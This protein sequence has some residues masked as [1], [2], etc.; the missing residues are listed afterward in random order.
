MVHITRI[1]KGHLPSLQ[2]KQIKDKILGKNYELSLVFTNDALSKSLHKKWQGKSGP[3]NIL[4]FP[5]S[6]KNGEIFI[7]PRTAY[8][9]S[10]KF[11]YP[12]FLFLGFLFIHG[13]CHL[14]GL[15]HGQ[16]MEKLE[17]KYRKMFGIRK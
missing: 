13:C 2:Y 17:E 12:N 3:A 11:G 8:R 16:K 10:K 14:K 7:N 4:S 1:Y 15:K 6:K 9:E 5:L